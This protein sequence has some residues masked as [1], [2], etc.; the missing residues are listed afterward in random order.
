MPA[1][2]SR[3]RGARMPG[4]DPIAGPVKSIGTPNG[5]MH[6]MI[7]RRTIVDADMRVI[8]FGQ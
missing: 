2:A 1:A 8:S 6:F 3:R 4:A 5:K 7:T